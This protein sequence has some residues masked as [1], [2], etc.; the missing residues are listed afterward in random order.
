MRLITQNNGHYAV[1]GHSSSPIS[2]PIESPYATLVTYIVSCAVFKLWPIIGRIFAIDRG[3]P[4]FNAPA[5]VIPCE[6]PDKLYLSG[7]ERDCPTRC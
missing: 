6:Y 7:N 2:V 5:G 3:V 1:H 4:H